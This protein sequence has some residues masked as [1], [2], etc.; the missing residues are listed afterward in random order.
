MKLMTPT[1]SDALYAL[2]KYSYRNCPASACPRCRI[3]LAYDLRP[4]RG[5]HPALVSDQH[6]QTYADLH[7]KEH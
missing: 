5:I 4:R 3:I 2:R 7:R 6:I 1:T